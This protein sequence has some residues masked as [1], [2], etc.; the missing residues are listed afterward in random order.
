MHK[1]KPESEKIFNQWKKKA[2]AKIIQSVKI[3]LY[4]WHNLY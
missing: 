4:E 2:P 3:I 1:F